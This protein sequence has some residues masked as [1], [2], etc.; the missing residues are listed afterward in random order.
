A[1][2][3]DF[4]VVITVFSVATS[5]KMLLTAYSLFTFLG[6]GAVNFMS[7]GFSDAVMY[8]SNVGVIFLI[9]HIVLSHKI[10]LKKSLA[11][12]AELMYKLF[13]KSPD[14]ILFI[15]PKRNE[16]VNCNDMALQLFGYTSRE[17][18]KAL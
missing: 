8:Q 14:A 9:F 4:L 7:N 5:D 1:F 17:E 12:K 3:V 11:A 15:D 16:I 18:F 13:S 6:F 10:E 2:F